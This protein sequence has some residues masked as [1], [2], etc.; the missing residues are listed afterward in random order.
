MKVLWFTNSPVSAA[1]KLNYEFV[2]EG[3]VSALENILSSEKEIKLGICCKGKVNNLNMFAIDKTNY[4]VVPFD[5][6]N[7]KRFLPTIKLKVNSKKNI[8]YY[9]KVIKEFNPDIINIFG[10]ENDYGLII[11][12]IKIPVVIHIQGNLTVYNLKYFNN[13]SKWDLLRYAGIKELLRGNSLLHRFYFLERSAARERQIFSWCNYFMGRT[14]WDKKIVSVL[15]PYSKYYHCEEVIRNEFFN[16][17]WER[18]TNKE[19]KLVSII[20]GNI[21]KG[22]DTV[23]ETSRLLKD[24][25]FSFEWQIIGSDIVDKSPQVY[26][27]KYR[28]RYSDINIKFLGKKNTQEVI[29]ILL[30]SDLFIHPSHIE[31]SPNSI[32]EAMVLG[33]PV[34]ATGTGGTQNILCN[35]LEGIIVQDG[36]PYAMAGAILELYHNKNMQDTYSQNA[37]KRARERHNG[38]RIVKELLSIYRTII[39]DFH[40]KVTNKNE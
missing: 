11:P 29:N 20:R 27:K 35:E 9:I 39:N 17:K 37:I 7:T 32:C 25:K 13:I 19:A 3:W 21:Y 4:F 12:L 6:D 36:D 2:G 8:D 10:S 34:I 15:S 40:K 24:L 22:I 1:K 26:E 28:I 18:N 33:M 23:I 30:D 16:Y 5:T 38:N 31:N 14:S